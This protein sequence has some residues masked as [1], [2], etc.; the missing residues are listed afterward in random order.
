MTPAEQHELHIETGFLSSSATTTILIDGVDLLQL[1]PGRPG[2][3]VPA[4]PV[5]LL[6]PDS[7][8]LLPSTEASSAMVGICNCGE[9]G[10]ASLWLRV[11]RDGDEVLWE[12]DPDT[13][14]LTVNRSWS[15]D[16]LPYLDAIDAGAR[17]VAAWEQR[18]R[19]LARELRRYR[20][21]LFG[22]NLGQLIHLTGARAWPGVD[23]VQVQVAGPH[24][25]D[26][27]TYP[28]PADLSDDAIMIEIG[29]HAQRRPRPY[30]PD[31]HELLARISAGPDRPLRGTITTTGRDRCRLDVWRE[32]PRLRV[33]HPDGSP[34]LIVGAES[35]WRFDASQ[36]LPL[37]IPDLGA[38]SSFVTLN[39]LIRELLPSAADEVAGV[40]L[41]S[42]VHRSDF[43][44][45]PTWSATLWRPDGLEPVQLEV[46]METGMALSERTK[47]GTVVE[48][49]ELVVG[50]A[51]DPAL[52][53]WDGPV[54]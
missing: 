37:E 46:D 20:D 26:F 30:A 27:F 25:P 40:H 8:A 38:A 17:S 24:G 36:D 1:Q 14:S 5:D 3:F 6:P 49:T 34:A 43:L 28:V 50:E 7:R 47:S 45:R 33:Q 42:A 44:G 52:F 39:L 32:G 13:P 29:R 12:P 18:P 23:E 10:D 35:A 41:E 31:P 11:R 53:T 21:S 48:W 2:R 19:I 16:L 22:P 4:D 54:R 15:F 9:P 51:P